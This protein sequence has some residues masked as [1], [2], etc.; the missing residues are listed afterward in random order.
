MLEIN[1]NPDVLSCLANLSNDEVFTPPE[2]VNEILDQLPQS[3]WSDSAATFLDPV[4]KSGVFLREIAKRLIGGLKDQFPDEQERIN[5]IF[6]AQ[7]FGI[8][9][10]ELTSLLARRSVYCSKTAN[11]P[12]SVCSEFDRSDGN[13]RFNRVDHTWQGTRCKYCGASHATM[14]RGDDLETH[15]YEFIHTDIP[16]SLFDMKFDVIIGNPPYQLSDGGHNASASPI[17]HKFVEQA[18]KLNPSYL[19]MIIPARWYS[20]GK[21]LDGFRADMLADKSIRKLVD[22]PKLYDAFPGVKIRGGVCYFLRDKN[23]EGPC[24]VQTMW[25]N[26][27]LGEPVERH[28]NQY[29][30]L[31]RRNEAI[32]ILEKVKAFREN[33]Q[34]ENTYDS[35]VSSSKPF[36]FR[37]NFH[38]RA[39]RRGLTDPVKLYGSQK[40][41]WIERAQ[42][43]QNAAWIDK[44]K[45]LMSA[46]QGT[47]AAIET[48]FLGAPKIAAPGEVC[49]ETYNVAGRF[50]DRETALRCAVYLKTR[51]VRFLVSLRK[52]AQHASRD[53][54]GFVPSVPLDRMWTDEELYSRY[55]LT[56]EEVAYIEDTVAPIAVG[57][58]QEPDDD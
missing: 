54:Y 37:T 8:A 46:V 38:G 28:L 26:V 6:N 15:A 47:S 23:Y 31:V 42:I 19:I 27:P 24:S 56:A 10:T 16:E 11:S 3:L 25:D 7:L 18:K 52:A 1:Y 50:D 21:G 22:Y 55:G 51:F 40:I 58:D 20:G 41:S 2:L 14:E 45:V 34:P 9:I 53:V 35:L 57:L 33:G 44:W 13:I 30:V 36:G 32:S 49:S 48:K 29:D 43:Q 39:Y 17:Y 12:F 4:C 5:H